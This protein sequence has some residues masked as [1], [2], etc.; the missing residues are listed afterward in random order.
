M[1]EEMK[2]ILEKI[3]EY[4]TILV[5]RH[6]RPDGDAVG[7]SM[8]LATLLKNTYPEKKIFV[9]NADFSDY[10]AFLGKE[11]ELLPDEA[12]EGALGIVVDTGTKERISNQKYT[13]C[14]ELI[15]I[16]HHIPMQSYANYEW[17]EEHRSSCC[18]MIAAFYEAF[19]DELK[20][21]KKAAT[22]IYTGMV[23]DSGRFRFREVAPQTMRLA[24]LILSQG[25]DTES[26]YANLYMKDFDSLKF[27]GYV[28][29]K[30]KISKNGVASVYV[31]SAMKEKFNLSNEQASSVVSYMETIK[32][33]LIWIAFIDSGDGSIRVRLRSRFVTVSELGERY[34]GGGHACA[35]GA[36]VY[37]VAEMKKLLKEADELLKEYKETH[38]G[39]L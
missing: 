23:T 39:W 31:D 13:L 15:K 9:Q 29:K 10:L 38:E 32:G 30:I 3:K 28:Y 12:Y 18:E 14:K 2:V 27:E 21:D 7:S 34:N 22:F 4:E 1:K 24:G 26:L 35:A 25:I 8:G 19:Q 5:F 17:V 20:M 16:D 6:F 11:D 36:T 37:S 33:S